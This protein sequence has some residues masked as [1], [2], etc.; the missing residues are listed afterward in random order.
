MTCFSQ[1][2]SLQVN[3]RYYSIF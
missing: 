3:S 1:I 2:S